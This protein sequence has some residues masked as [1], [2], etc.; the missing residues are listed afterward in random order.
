MGKLPL[1]GQLPGK[2]R[3]RKRTYLTECINQLVLESQLLHKTVNLLL[4]IS[5]ENKKLT[6]LWGS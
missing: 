3:P 6:L 5:D 4:T 1:I 2:N